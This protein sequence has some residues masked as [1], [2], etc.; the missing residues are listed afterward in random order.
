VEVPPQLW[1]PTYQTFNAGGTMLE[2]TSVPRFLPGQ[3][4]P[5]HGHWERADVNTHEA[6]F[7]AFIL[8][9]GDPNTVPPNPYKRGHVRIEQVITFVDGDH[10]QSDARTLF[11]D[12]NG[13]L[14]LQG[15]ANFVA[16]R[17]P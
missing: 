4:G 11:R 3:R 2:T 17:M 12:V 1:S 8:F 14:Y 9:D 10:W 13:N 16:T 6:V 15:C 5:G 7:Q